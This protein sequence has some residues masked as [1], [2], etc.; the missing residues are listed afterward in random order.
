MAEQA[1]HDLDEALPALAEAMKVSYFGKYD[2][3]MLYD[4]LATYALN[5][6]KY[7]TMI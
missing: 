7:K 6:V 1:Q 4:I 5:L 2:I 3:R